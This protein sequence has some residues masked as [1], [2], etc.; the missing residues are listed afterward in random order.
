MAALRTLSHTF[1]KSRT[2]D[3]RRRS[4]KCRPLSQMALAAMHCRVV[5][6]LNDKIKNRSENQ[7][8]S[9]RTIAASYCKETL[10][11]LR[12]GNRQHRRK[13]YH[14]EKC[15]PTRRSDRQAIRQARVVLSDSMMSSKTSGTPTVLGIS[16]QAPVEERLRTV[17]S[18]TERL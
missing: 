18:N 7:E 3:I 17:Q 2:R 8:P 11:Q 12:R 15:T 4:S 14:P 9:G 13:S 5:G 16:R 10:S 6:A 1:H